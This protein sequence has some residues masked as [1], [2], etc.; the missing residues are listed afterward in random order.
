MDV[1]FSEWEDRDETVKKLVGKLQIF[2]GML[3]SAK[4]VV[5]GLN[6]GRRSLQTQKNMRT[7][8][9]GVLLTNSSLSGLSEC[10]S[11]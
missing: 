6:K 3:M 7:R 4:V 5:L 2:L 8:P 9:S 10:L 11:V 1:F